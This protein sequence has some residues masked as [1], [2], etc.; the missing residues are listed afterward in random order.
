[1][2]I[3]V[4]AMVFI[5][6]CQVMFFII[7]L[8]IPFSLVKDAG[9]NDGSDDPAFG[10][11]FLFGFIKRAFGDLL[12]LFV[13]WKNDRAILRALGAAILIA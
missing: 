4:L 7:I 3:A 12:L 6:N 9:R 13:E 11:V 10:S 5:R 1:M 2:R 8:M